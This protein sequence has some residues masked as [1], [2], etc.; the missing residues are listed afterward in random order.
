MF[1]ALMINLVGARRW[2]S[3]VIGRSLVVYIKDR[4][5]RGSSLRAASYLGCIE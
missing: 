3:L 1:N 4:R 2:M 5:Q